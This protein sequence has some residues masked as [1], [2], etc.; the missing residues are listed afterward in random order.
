VHDDA[1]Y[2]SSVDAISLRQ[3][4]G[5]PVDSA[6]ARQR[7][8]GREPGY[9]GECDG[10]ASSGMRYAVER[11]ERGCD[12][13]RLG[14]CGWRRV[15]CV[16]RGDVYRRSDGA[17]LALR[18]AGP[19][20][21]SCCERVPGSRCRSGAFGPY[22]G[23]V[24]GRGWPRRAAS[25]GPPSV[26]VTGLAGALTMYTGTA[27]GSRLLRWDAVSVGLGGGSLS[28]EDVRNG[29]GLFAIALRLG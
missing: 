20:G 5:R 13:I 22:S 14:K 9:G 6:S 10:Y 24:G 25:S 18:G 19:R 1:G 4:A 3:Q 29:T 8:E 2:D 26:E 15:L 7:R 16:R 17:Q 21:C 12:V 11:A 23:L 27:I 28:D